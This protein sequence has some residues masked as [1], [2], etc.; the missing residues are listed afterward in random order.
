MSRLKLFRKV[1]MRST[2]RMQSSDTR[3]MVPIDWLLYSRFHGVIDGNLLRELSALEY[4]SSIVM[5]VIGEFQIFLRKDFISMKS[6]KRIKR[7]K[8]IKS[9]RSDFDL[10]SH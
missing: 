5:E 8:S 7:I 2:R 3:I 4:F 9:Q 6:I 1:T 10:L